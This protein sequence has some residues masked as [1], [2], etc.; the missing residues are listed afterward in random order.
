MTE[1]PEQLRNERIGRY[2][3]DALDGMARIMSA[4]TDSRHYVEGKLWW[5]T[6]SAIQALAEM[7]VSVEGE[8]FEDGGVAWDIPEVWRVIADRNREGSALHQI[9]TGLQ[10]ANETYIADD[11]F[12]T[13]FTS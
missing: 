7:G 4:G 12:P 9:W 1:S 10:H 5:A 6:R 3:G 11:P 13:G 2:L 8:E